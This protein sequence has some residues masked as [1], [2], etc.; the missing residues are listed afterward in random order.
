[1]RDI[2]STRSVYRSVTFEDNRA[3]TIRASDTA[4]VNL[5]Q[6]QLYTL[7]GSLPAITYKIPSR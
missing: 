6:Y 4:S 1:M 3:A 7:R 5:R 2:L